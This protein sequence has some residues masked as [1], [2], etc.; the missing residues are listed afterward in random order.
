MCRLFGLHADKRVITATFWL[1]DAPDNL[2]EQSKRNPDG[3]DIPWENLMQR[4]KTAAG[5]RVIRIDEANKWRESL[6]SGTRPP[7]VD[8][9]SWNWFRERTSIEFDSDYNR[10]L[11]V[12]FTVKPT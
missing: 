1:L 2:V 7:E 3:W 6:Q 9:T 5:G 10:P 4:L 8:S 11:F 12:E